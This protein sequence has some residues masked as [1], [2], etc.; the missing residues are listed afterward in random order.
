MKKCFSVVMPIYGV[1]KWLQEALDSIIH[2]ENINFLDDVEII[3]VNDC[4]PDNSEKI[5]LEYSRKYPNNV[6]YFKNN[7]NIGA[8]GS[9]N[10][11]L[12]FATGKYISFL[13]PDDTLSANV[14]F[15]V[16]ST[17]EKYGDELAHISIPLVFFE[18]AKGIHPKYKALGNKDRIID[19]DIE[20]FNFILSAASSFYLRESIANIRF[21]T[22]MIAE[23][24]TLFN[25]CLYEKNKKIGYICEN[26]VRY[27]YRRRYDE[28]SQVNLNA[29]KPEAYIMPIYLLDLVKIDKKSELFYELIIYELRSR[30]KK[31]EPSLF[32]N[33]DYFNQL[34]DSYTHYIRHIPLDYLLKSTT[35]IDFDLRMMFL[36]VF[37]RRKLSVDSNGM[38]FIDKESYIRCNN[39]PLDIK[40]FEL[41]K[42]KLIIEFILNDYDIKD[43]EVVLLDG[44]KNVI[45]PVISYYVDSCH[46]KKIGSWQTSSELL[47][48][49]FELPITILETYKFYF[50]RKSNGYLHIINK[51]RTYSES[52]F[53]PNAVF[54]SS[55]F[56][57]YSNLG[58][59]ISFFN[60][61]IVIE[62]CSFFEKKLNRLKSFMILKRK[63]GKFK[64]L[65][66]LKKGEPKYWLFNDRPINANDNAEEFFSFINKEY[67]SI[68]KK[69]YFVLDKNSPDLDRLKSIGNVVIQNSNK[70]K[71]LYINAKYIFTSHLA[72]SFFKPF[73]IGF[74]KYYNDLFDSKIIWLQHGI[75]MNDIEVAANKF[76]KHIHKVVVAAKYE[77]EIFLQPK[78]FYQNNDIYETGFTR[79]DKLKHRSSKCK[80]KVVLIM[81]TWRSYLSGKILPNGLH[82]EI[83]GFR[84]SEYFKQFQLLLSSPKLHEI[85][86]EYDYTVNF[87]LHPGFRQYSPYFKGLASDKIEITDQS[88]ISYSELFNTSSVLIT[89][90]SSVF[91]DFSYTQKPTLFFQF[92]REK[93]Y[94]GHYKEGVFKFDSMAPGPVKFDVE[95]LI[96]S[97]EE[98]M[99]NNGTID[100]K[101]L[102]RI[103]DLYL[104]VD[105]NNSSRLLSEIL[106]ND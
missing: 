22:S 77:R 36:K 48:G 30:L 63:H 28:S 62:K 31:L 24:D 87:V 78:F 97:L 94:S 42:S 11:G 67:P 85:L 2:Q 26:G 45:N 37:Q 34:V 20:P 92:D 40:S 79:Y 70:H 98:I 35:F 81:P 60:R 8:S 19:L 102:R 99:V 58:I 71:F 57:Q 103:K 32:P 5:C 39:L 86:D 50:R 91:F 18:A 52:P 106:A 72:T 61:K 68:A 51:L 15:E 1:E 27:N 101:Y 93:F 80:S 17:F 104:N 56:K 29:I 43:F 59:S 13:D 4:S 23:E 25:F 41:N 6:F 10:K 7:L 89:D 16:K 14:F 84:E 83:D 12:D 95:S 3:L 105:H 76:N 74:Y 21:N 54:S 88:S 64:W 73:T 90:Y 96:L 33:I 82:G 100:S 46:I 69:C 49:R 47:Y 75:T 44:N 66:L 38:I 9:R 53:L 65:R 55:K